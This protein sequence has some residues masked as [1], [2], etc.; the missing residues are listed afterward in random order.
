LVYF[1]ETESWL[2]TMDMACTVS[3]ATLG[4]LIAAFLFLGD[5]SV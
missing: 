1:P 2:V 4:I 5:Y 3:V